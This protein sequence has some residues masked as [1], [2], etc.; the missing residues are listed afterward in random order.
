M[1][2]TK[3]ARGGNIMRNMTFSKEPSRYVRQD[4]LEPRG[5]SPPRKM[6]TTY[7][8]VLT[9]STWCVTPAG[10]R[11][12]CSLHWI[13]GPRRTVSANFIVTS[14]E[15][16]VTSSATKSEKGGELGK[17]NVGRIRE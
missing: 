2:L 8:Q 1:H 4:A 12:C 17:G 10:R 5:S 11:R 6:R 15:D 9:V 16:N 7:R 14:L 3:R 13:Q